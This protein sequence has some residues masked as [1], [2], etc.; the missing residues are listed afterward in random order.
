[1]MIHGLDGHGWGMG[2]GW[3]LGLLFLILLVFVIIRL[4]YPSS[5]TRRSEE[6]SALDILKE[7]YAKG[8]I[9][10]TEFEERKIDLTNS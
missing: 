4:V 1:M 6:K 5:S 2:W 7:R 3:I 9:D 10:K 8:D